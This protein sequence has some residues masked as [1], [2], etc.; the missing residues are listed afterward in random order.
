MRG[1]TP[2]LIATLA[3][4]AL[5]R[6]APAQAA[7]EPRL[8]ATIDLGVV[9]A[10]GNTRLRTVN[11]AEQLV[12][13]TAPWKF[14]QTF[15]IVNGSTNGVE[16]ANNIRAGLRAD[17]GF[18]AH[19]RAY[20]LVLY[21][22][23]RFAGIARRFEESIGA[24]YGALT[25]PKHILDIEA[26]AGN[27]QQRG[28]VG[29]VESYWLG[30]VAGRYRYAIRGNSYVEEKLEILENLEATAD[31]RVNSEATLVAPFSATIALRFGYLVRFDN[32]PEPTFKKTDQIVSSGVQIVF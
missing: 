2:L 13:R 18:S 8:R 9:N 24:T 23:N 31:T 32:R 29:A 20:T 6:T 17:Y 30:R 14:T 27:N 7:A 28:I 5:P 25:G 21:E 22:R 3:C 11:A 16:T 19:V 4:A 15:S 1:S 26:G 10:S 12:Y